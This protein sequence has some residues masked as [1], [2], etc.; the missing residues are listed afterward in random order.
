MGISNNKKGD[1]VFDIDCICI[2]KKN[3]RLKSRTE[4]NTRESVEQNDLLKQKRQRHH[5]TKVAVDH[6]E[7][8]MKVIWQTR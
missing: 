3:K 4:V 5:K 1:E 2:T 6:R 7:V 8:E